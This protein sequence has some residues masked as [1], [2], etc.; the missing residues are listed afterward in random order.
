MVVALSERMEIEPDLNE[1]W[2]ALYDAFLQSE[3]CAAACGSPRWL[4]SF[5]DSLASCEWTLDEL[6]LPTLS[7]VLYDGMG[8]TID[9]APTDPEAVA[10]ELHAFLRWA[11]RAGGVT[12]SP[13]YEACCVYLQ[14]NEGI[15]G[16]SKWLTPITIEWMG[17][18]PP[19]DEPSQLEPVR[20]H[21]RQLVASSS[22]FAKRP[23]G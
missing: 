3:D 2:R 9:A 6:D 23:H 21:R 15:A 14:S 8:W 11:A 4:F 19:Q 18:W 20:P 22:P 16:I 1:E 10:R 5:L 17:E 13:A 12:S 7:A